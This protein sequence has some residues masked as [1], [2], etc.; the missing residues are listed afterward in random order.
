M[1]HN[2]Y[3]LKGKIKCP[4]CNFHFIPEA[5]QYEKT[6][7]IE[8]KS[9]GEPLKVKNKD[10]Q[11]ILK[12]YTEIKDSWVTY[13]PDCGYL[14]KFVAEVGKKEL[15]EQSS[16]ILKRGA[17]EEFGDTFKYKFKSRQ[18]A[19]MDYLDYL[20][21]KI[22]GIKADIKKALDEVNFT[23]WGDPYI[24]WMNDKSI[25]SFKFLIHFQAN[26]EDYCNSQLPDF[27]SMDMMEKIKACNLPNELEESLAKVQDL[28]NKI[29]HDV[30]EL[31]EEED[32]IVE[33]AFI[34]FAY[35]LV[36][37]QLKPLNLDD[38]R[39]DPE[40]D[41]IDINKINYEIQE[42]LRLYL[43][44]ILRIKEFDDKFLF[45]LL[46]HLGIFVH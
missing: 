34:Q 5:F 11:L 16:R 44:D 25:D 10:H 41:F 46:S 14:M 15:V 19:Y 27:K 26:I 35:Y 24:E 39:I 45:P 37:K 8:I 9:K 6:N 2:K 3:P 13:C 32:E 17:F 30:Y 12:P 31:S 43:Y 29:A 36:G 38:I 42:F 18:K 28:L 20:I 23:R 21:E 40:H 1:K 33:R 22:D 4:V 7:F